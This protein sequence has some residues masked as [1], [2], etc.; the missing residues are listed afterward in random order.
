MHGVTRHQGNRFASGGKMPKQ[1]ESHQIEPNRSRR[2][3]GVG[4]GPAS[5]PWDPSIYSVHSKNVT[6]S[7]QDLPLVR[8]EIGFKSIGFR[9]DRSNRP[10]DRIFLLNTDFIVKNHWATIRSGNHGCYLSKLTQY[11]IKAAGIIQLV[12]SLATLI[13]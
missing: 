4:Y 8:S 7:S 9:C 12:I 2:L 6:T 5:P 1:G 10:F 11:R 3:P 13:Q